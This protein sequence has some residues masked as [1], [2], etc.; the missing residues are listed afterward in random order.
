[1]EVVKVTDSKTI[2]RFSTQV[3]EVFS[4]AQ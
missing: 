1:M 3:L 4:S 2:S